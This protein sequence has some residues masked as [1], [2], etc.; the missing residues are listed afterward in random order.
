MV[1][2]AAFEENEVTE[3]FNCPICLCLVYEPQTCVKCQNHLYCSMCIEQMENKEC[4]FCKGNEF[5]KNHRMLQTILDNTKV[6][7]PKPECKKWMKYG[8]F[9]DTHIKMCIKTTIKCPLGCGQ[10]I[11]SVNGD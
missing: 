1:N 2:E 3:G 10:E 9:V 5:Q 4:G 6:E 8:E 7:C 11:T